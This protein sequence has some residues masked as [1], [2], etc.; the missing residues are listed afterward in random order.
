MTLA[1]GEQMSK[2]LRPKLLYVAIVA[3]VL[4]GAAAVSSVAG[5]DDRWAFDGPVGRADCGPGSRPESGLQGSIPIPER[6]S[7]RSS[8]GYTCNM[9]QVGRYAGEGTEWQLTWYEDCAYYDTKLS[10]SQQ[11]GARSSSTS[12]TRP[13]RS[14]P[15]T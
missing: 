2:A 6:A 10:G 14:S 12:R 13:I 7:G 9:T 8:E 3:V 1:L 5:A 15:P 4:S 11:N